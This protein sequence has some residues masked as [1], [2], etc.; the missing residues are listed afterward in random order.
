[1]IAPLPG[2]HITDH[3]MRLYMK[4][5]ET[6]VPPVVA[7]K[8][9]LSE[10]TAHPLKE[11]HRLCS[12][13]PEG[14]TSSGPISWAA[15]FE[16]EVAPLRESWPELRPAA[17]F[18]EM[19]RHHLELGDRVRRTI[20]RRIRDWRAL[21]GAARDMIFR[22]THE[23]GRMGLSD[24]TDTP[25]LAVTVTAAPLDRSIPAELSRTGNAS[26]R[27]VPSPTPVRRP[28][29]IAPRPCGLSPGGHE[30]EPQSG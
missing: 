22:Q 9:R 21:R 14:G 30:A 8:A 26:R 3:Q 1:V 10:A 18:A 13:E 2:C 7:A 6:D 28:G 24:L 27:S 20:E 5:R 12:Q 25:G 23:P 17:I 19:C 11:D 4:H 29:N 15:I 16:A